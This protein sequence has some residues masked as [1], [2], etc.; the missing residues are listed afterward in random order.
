M[1]LPRAGHPAKLSNQGRR[2]LAREVTKDPMVTPTELS[3][4]SVE[5]GEHSRKTTISAEFHQS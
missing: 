2:A 4:S 3:S 5:M 1:T